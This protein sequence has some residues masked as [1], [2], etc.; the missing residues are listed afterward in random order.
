[1][2]GGTKGS[3]ATFPVGTKVSSTNGAYTELQKQLGNEI[4]GRQGKKYRLVQAA[5]ADGTGGRTR[6]YEWVVAAS[7]TVD[8][9]DAAVTETPCGIGLAAQESLAAGDLF[10]L[11][12]EGRA[13]VLNDAAATLAVDT[14]ICPS[15]TVAGSVVAIGDVTL[16]E[17]NTIVGKV[18]TST[19]ASTATTDGVQLRAGL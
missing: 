10:W 18:L 16:T 7:H 5:T 3:I 17:S 14:V 2:A 1:M 11:Q 6:V 19:A 8:I 4:D 9:A 12:I 15:G 13:A